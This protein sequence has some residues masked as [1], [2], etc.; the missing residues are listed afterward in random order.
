MTENLPIPAPDDSG[1]FLLYQTE[2]RRTR[3][4]VRMA[5]VIDARF[6]HLQQRSSMVCSRRRSAVL[7][8]FSE[9]EYGE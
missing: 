2:D 7:C 6:Q 3:L 8:H 1:E 5:H 9:A 4:E